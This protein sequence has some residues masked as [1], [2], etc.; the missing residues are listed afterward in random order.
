MHQTAYRMFITNATLFH[1]TS[2]TPTHLDTYCF[3]G[4]NA[5][6]EHPRFSSLPPEL[7]SI[8]RSGFEVATVLL[9][10]RRSLRLV[11]SA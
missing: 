6:K 8:T 4:S 1:Q 10:L 9:A 11:P 2:I 7:G 5:A 3:C